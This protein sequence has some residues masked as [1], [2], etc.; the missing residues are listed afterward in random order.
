MGAISFTHV[1][2]LKPKR[3]VFNKSHSVSFPGTMGAL[4]P[5]MTDFLVPG[6]TVKLSDS[7]HTRTLALVSPIMDNVQTYVH[8]WNVPIRLVDNKFKQFIGNEID[9]SE[10]NPLFYTPAGF[11]DGLDNIS[12]SENEE[13]MR[14]YLNHKKNQQE[15][16]KEGYTLKDQS[17]FR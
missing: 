1:K 13:Y 15:Y 10:Y 16:K 8:Y 7:L 5:V 17:H 2:G 12:W 14:Y 4:M 3:N 6:S 11:F 9:P